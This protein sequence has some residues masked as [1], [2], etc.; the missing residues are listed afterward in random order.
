MIYFQI[1][2]IVGL[3]IFYM[4]INSNY[5][6]MIPIFILCIIAWPVAIYDVFIIEKHKFNKNL[7]FK[8]DKE[9]NPEK[10]I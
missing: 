1:G 4:D 9:I 8:T 6:K 5:Y 10:F 2:L 3:I 7:M